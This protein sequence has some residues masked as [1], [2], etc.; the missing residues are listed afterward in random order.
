[1]N[2][3][4][5]I[6]YSDSLCFVP[7]TDIPCCICISYSMS[8]MYILAYCSARP[9]MADHESFQQ[10][11]STFQCVLL[12]LPFPLLSTQSIALNSCPHGTLRLSIPASSHHSVFMLRLSSHGNPTIHC[13]LA[14]PS[15]QP[16]DFMEWG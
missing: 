5:G 4:G 10:Q 9:C 15:L 13:Y 14:L 7:P 6:F 12:A 8:P 3:K 16:D 2:K 11:T 1:M